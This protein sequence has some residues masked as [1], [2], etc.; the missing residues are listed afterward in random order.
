M[1][2]DTLRSWGAYEVEPMEVY[3]DIFRL[4]EGAIQRAGQDQRDMRA[5]PL[6]YWRNNGASKGHYRILFEDTFE[7]TL[8]ELQEA[9][10]CI[11]NGLTYFGRRNTQERASKM[12]ALIF[13]LDGITE[14]T[15]NNFM[16]GAI[17]AGV[18]PVPNYIALSG[19]GVHLYYV[20][21]EELSLY[22]AIKLQ[23][24][25]LKYAL[26]DKIWNQY[27]S[28]QEVKQYQGINQGFR[29]IGGRTKVEGVR[30]KAFRVS[31]HPISIE[32]LGE[33]VPEESRVDPARHWKESRM[34]LEEA[35]E[36][37]PKWYESRTGSE[38]GHWIC[39]RELYDWWKRQIKAGATLHHRYFSIMCLAIYGIKAGITAE[40][41]R[42][43]AEGL[44]P[45]MNAIAPSD[46]FTLADVES[47]LECFDP[48]YFTFPIED[49]E[50]ISGI[51]IERNKR[52]Y[53]R[54]EW[55]LEDI[56]AKKERMKRRGQAFKAPEGRPNKAEL[57][58]SWRRDHPEG[59]RAECVRALGIDWKTARKYWEE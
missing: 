7:K 14:D 24:K 29:C 13:D 46:P 5:N 33:Y 38:R 37:Y 32:R 20:L 56:R 23:A 50:R 16:S 19:H 10:F 39:K 59:T 58:K 15:L 49:I 40:E 57:V 18:Y 21:E 36:K 2:E 48:G 44:I 27:T 22:P 26:T 52:N 35:R 1:L 47:A 11:V 42:A 28:T 55:H 43:D 12:Y 53:Q 31:D 45:F 25:A 9:D 6:G 41:V 8:A 30:V 3:R 34:S 54:Q 4:G 51:K 17:V